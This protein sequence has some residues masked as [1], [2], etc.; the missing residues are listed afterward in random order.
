MT[1]AL[2]NSTSTDYQAWYD[3]QYSSQNNNTYIYPKKNCYRGPPPVGPGCKTNF[4][5]E[6][7]GGVKLLSMLKGWVGYLAIWQYYMFL[8][9]LATIAEVYFPSGPKRRFQKV[10]QR[11]P[12]WTVTFNRQWGVPQRVPLRYL[13]TIG[14]HAFHS[15]CFLIG[16]GFPV[17]K[18]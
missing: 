10:N 3:D 5:P 15:R 14:V 2:C 8:P 16:A 1:Y 7:V 12:R 11:A 13:L 6:G 9:R 17:I 18:T 4:F